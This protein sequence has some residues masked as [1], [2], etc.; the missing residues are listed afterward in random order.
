MSNLLTSCNR[1]S[2]KTAPE[3]ERFGF[4]AELIRQL[5]GSIFES[6]ENTPCKTCHH[7]SVVGSEIRDATDGC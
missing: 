3:T 6:S 5:L 4:G 2:V 1:P 7:N